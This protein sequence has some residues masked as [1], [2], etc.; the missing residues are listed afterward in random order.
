MPKNSSYNITLYEQYNYRLG[1]DIVHTVEGRKNY[2]GR[3]T[4]TTP[5][6]KFITNIK[7]Y[8]LDTRNERIHVAFEEPYVGK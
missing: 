4:S 1:G 3:L 5:P 2:F 8:G 7:L 6:S